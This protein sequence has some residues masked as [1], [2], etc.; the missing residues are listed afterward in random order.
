M[1]QTTNQFEYHESRV[2]LLITCGASDIPWPHIPW[3]LVKM[4]YIPQ[5]SFL[6]R[7]LKNKSHSIAPNCTFKMTNSGCLKPHHGFSHGFSHIF[8]ILCEKNHIPGGQKPQKRH[9]HPPA[10]SLPSGSARHS[11]LG[12]WV[13]PGHSSTIEA[14]LSR[15]KWDHP[16]PPRE[17]FVGLEA[18]WSSSIDLAYLSNVLSIFLLP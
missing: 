8:P 15:K 18:R 17:K 14:Q 10:S 16:E 2:L 4:G 12:S 1:F 5:N 3:V 11:R 13:V 9:R 6:L 7:K